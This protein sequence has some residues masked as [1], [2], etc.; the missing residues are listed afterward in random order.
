MRSLI[1]RL[2]EQAERQIEL[3]QRQVDARDLIRRYI[4]LVAL[5]LDPSQQLTSMVLFAA[6]GD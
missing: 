5:L 4:A 2:L 3:A 6:I 1:V